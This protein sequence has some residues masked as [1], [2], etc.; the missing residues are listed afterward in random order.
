MEAFGIYSLKAGILL[1][2]FWGIYLLFLQRE[3]FCRFNRVFLLTGLIAAIIFPLIVVRYTVEVSSQVLPIA[4]LETF[5]AGITQHSIFLQLCNQLLPFI[6][7][8]GLTILF[9]VRSIG[10]VRLFISI[11]RNKSARY[12]GYPIVESSEYNCAFSFFGFIFIPS[13][14]NE[15]EKQI[16][17]QHENAH[18]RQK[19]WIDLF[20][21][22]ILSLLWWF[23]PVIWLY[24][25]AIRN[26]HEYLA[27][28]E[29]LTGCQQE[30]YHQVLLNQWFHTPVFP[31]TNLFSFNNNL[32]RINMM[33]RNISNP[34]RKLYAFLAVPALALFLMAFSEKVYV[35]QDPQRESRSSNSTGMDTLIIRNNSGATGT[36]LYYVDA[37][38]VQT[39][40]D[41]KPDD[42]ESISV[43]KDASATDIYGDKGK[44]G[45]VLITTKAKVQ[46]EEVK[47]RAEEIKLQD[48]QHKL[49]TEQV[50]LQDE[51]A[52]LQAE[53]VKIFGDFIITNKPITIIDGKE[54]PGIEGINP[55]DIESISVLKD[56][57][58]MSR[59]G[60]KGKNGV[61]IIATKKESR[62]N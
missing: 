14:L 32:K 2:V 10:I 59:Y 33:K 45:V 47:L 15:D 42:I 21:T 6:F 53:Q 60:E 36:P 5:S 3:T 43:L 30:N 41:L 1:T 26:N 48:E 55:A 37:K 52:K 4:G 8:M 62:E 38:E 58:A 57:S 34:F 56:A 20:F 54:V 61:I 28:R 11:R 44:N 18:I 17:L 13:N 46:I 25:K 40:S 50:K 19:H 9:I 12:A 31:I 22:N 51:E 39:I 23:N 27:D 7:L 49:Q 35:E 24:E 16:I 29:V